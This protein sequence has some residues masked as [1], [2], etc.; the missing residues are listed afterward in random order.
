MKNLELLRCL[1]CGGN[2][3]WGDD[4]VVVCPYCKSEYIKEQ[5]FTTYS[6]KE[7]DVFQVDTINLENPKVIINAYGKTFEF[8]VSSFEME[9]PSNIDTYSLYDDTIRTVIRNELPDIN[10]HLVGIREIKERL[11]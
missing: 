5:G 7:K 6:E 2:L 9:S 11:E 1:N 10:M 4:N 3:H 8:Y